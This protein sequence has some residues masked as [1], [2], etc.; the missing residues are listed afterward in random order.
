MCVSGTCNR[1]GEVASCCKEVGHGQA[2]AAPGCLVRRQ[3]VWRQR[4]AP[5]R[6][7]QRNRL[8]HNAALW[9]TVPPAV[10]LSRQPPHC[11]QSERMLGCPESGVLKAKWGWEAPGEG[12]GGAQQQGWDA[13]QPAWQTFRALALG[14]AGRHPGCT[15]EVPVSLRHR[16]L[17]RPPLSPCCCLTDSRSHPAPCLVTRGLHCTLLI[18]IP[19]VQGTVGI[20]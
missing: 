11:H 3:R 10:P 1:A 15:L 13:Y 17:S 9:G 18:P 19:T 16:G 8:T 14:T 5:P 6:L 20:M 2:P 12:L 4:G 7:R